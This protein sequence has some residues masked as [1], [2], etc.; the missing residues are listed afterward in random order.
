MKRVVVAVLVLVAS[1]VLAGHGDRDNRGEKAAVDRGRYVR[2][3]G[4]L[5]KDVEELEARNED[6]P[7][8]QDRKWIRERLAEMRKDLASVKSDVESAPTA[9]AIDP[10]IPPPPLPPPSGPIPP[11]FGT[12][13]TP[14]EYATLHAE[15]KKQSFDSNRL[16]LVREVSG[17]AWFTTDQVIQ[18]MGLFSFSTEKIQAGA[19]MY[20]RVVDR[21]Q[22]YRVY[23]TLTF[24]SDQEKLR[25]LT[26]GK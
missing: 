17:S 20:P 5:L 19:A 22:W 14:Q 16:Q 7:N 13:M 25:K 6:N 9:G 21:D 1:P 12:A 4:Q 23:S 2:T 24:S 10:Y 8:K 18:T 26:S 11:P 15:L 3:L